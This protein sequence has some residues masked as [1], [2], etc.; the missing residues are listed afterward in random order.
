MPPN[1]G[2]HPTPLVR[3]IGSG[4]TRFVVGWSAEVAST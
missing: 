2:F 4:Y 1:K 3:L